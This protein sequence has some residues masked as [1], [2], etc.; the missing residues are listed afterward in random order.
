MRRLL[1]A[2]TN[3]GK[4]ME[5][6]RALRRLGLDLVAPA[7]IGVVLDVPEDGATLE[8]N[9]AQ[10]A[11]AYLEALP[12]GD[13]VVLADDT[14]VEIDAL[15]GE[16]GHHVRRW[17]GQGRLSDEEV[18]A[19][20]L[21][22]LA[23]VPPAQRGAQFRTVFALGLP[24]GAVEFTT[25]TLRGVILEQPDPLRIEGF[26]FESLFFV[27]AWD[28]L[29]GTI[30]LLPDAEKACC[31]THREQALNAALPRLRALMTE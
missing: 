3:P 1:Y 10:K 17:T 23:G 20:C 16:P 24:G 31:I 11:R 29:L 19:V 7:E 27:P 2:T 13:T 4:I 28:R 21:Q 12:D 14:G 26:P 25:G 9:A 30:H 22:R 5:T 6:R 15:G 8:A 18:I